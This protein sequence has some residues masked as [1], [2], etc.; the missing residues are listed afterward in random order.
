MIEIP[1]KHKQAIKKQYKMAIKLNDIDCSAALLKIRRRATD[2][3][4]CQ[5]EIT[6]IFVEARDD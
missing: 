6:K 1:E 5:D 2:L 3:G 4:Y